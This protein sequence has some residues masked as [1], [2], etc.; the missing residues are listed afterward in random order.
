MGVSQM[1]ASFS[2]PAWACPSTSGDRLRHHQDTN[3]GPACEG[4]A[5]VCGRFREWDRMARIAHLLKKPFVC[6]GSFW[7][8]GGS[9]CPWLIMLGVA[10]G[11][12]CPTRHKLTPSHPTHWRYYM[13]WRKSPSLSLDRESLCGDLVEVQCFLRKGEKTQLRSDNLVVQWEWREA[14]SGM[15]GV[16]MPS[17]SDP[18]PATWFVVHIRV[19]TSQRT[20]SEGVGE[21]NRNP[22]SCISGTNGIRDGMGDR[23]SHIVSLEIHSSRA[24][25]KSP[26]GKAGRDWPLVLHLSVGRI[27]A[28]G[29]H[30]RAWQLSNALPSCTIR[31]NSC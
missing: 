20:G 28:T 12:D 30:L 15:D 11:R 16:S 10:V 25:S 2:E 4:Q 24:P 18:I 23:N 5:C 7:Y 14:W 9:A 31:D 3:P 21:R 6:G 26:L 13:Y 27:P 19:Q 29:P 22:Q 8:P 17:R 1:S